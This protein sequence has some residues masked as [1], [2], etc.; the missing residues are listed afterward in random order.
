MSSARAKAQR[1]FALE[2]VA[3]NVPVAPCEHG[4]K[5]LGV[6]GTLIAII[7]LLVR[8]ARSIE[9]LRSDL[10]GPFHELLIGEKP[11]R[12]ARSESGESLGSS[13]RIAP[14]QDMIAIGKRQ[15][16]RG[17]RRKDRERIGRDFKF[18]TDLGEIF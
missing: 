16:R 3:Q 18:T 9:P 11:V 12:L 17:V 1:I 6:R 14:N 7:E 13:L 10:L 15:E 5:Y 8:R 4:L 2:E